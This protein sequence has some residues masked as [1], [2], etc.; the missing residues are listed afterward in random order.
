MR[1]KKFRVNFI[2]FM[3]GSVKGGLRSPPV[4]EF[5]LNDTVTNLS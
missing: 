2:F 4:M 5:G 1:L 3:V